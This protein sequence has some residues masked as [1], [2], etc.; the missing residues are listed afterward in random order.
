M[1]R[2]IPNEHNRPN[3]S[4]CAHRLRRVAAFLCLASGLT[5]CGPAVYDATTGKKIA[6][7][8]YGYDFDV[9][10]NKLTMN[11]H[12]TD[13]M[14]DVAGRAFEYAIDHGPQHAPEIIKAFGDTT[15]SGGQ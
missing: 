7:A 9:A 2:R 1:N 8:P 3:R 4:G 5:A 6:S 10:A 12:F 13:R 14:A 15:K 11:Q